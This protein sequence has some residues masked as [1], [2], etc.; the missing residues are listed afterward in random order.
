M[1]HADAIP[2]DLGGVRLP[3]PGRPVWYFYVFWIPEFLTRERGLNLAGI[4]LVAWI[5]F[6]AADVANFAGGYLTMRLQRAGWSVNRTRKTIMTASALLSPIGIFAVFAHSLFWTI[7]LISIAIFVWMFWSISV[8][9]LSGD[10]FPAAGGGVG[11]RDGGNRIHVGI[12][13]QHVGSRTNPRFD[14]QLHPGIHRYRDPDACSAGHRPD[15]DAA[16]G[17]GRRSSDRNL[18]QIGKPAE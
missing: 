15:L 16:G 18:L 14:A 7:G 13:D 17:T 6:L 5:P 8:H 11:V 9:S 3:V 12:G 4:G 2:A 1:D 10:Y